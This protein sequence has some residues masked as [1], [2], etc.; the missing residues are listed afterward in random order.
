MR[1][2]YIRVLQF[3]SPKTEDWAGK[4]L[5]KYIAFKRLI[6]LFDAKVEYTKI[7]SIQVMFSL[8]LIL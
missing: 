6:K 1:I 8:L 3:F 5:E 7:Y 2:K 4:L